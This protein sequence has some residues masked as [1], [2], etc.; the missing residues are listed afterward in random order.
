MGWQRLVRSQR[1]MRRRRQCQLAKMSS[2]G[3]IEPRH[4]CHHTR[5]YLTPYFS[6]VPPQRH[7]C[8]ILPTPLSSTTPIT[9]FNRHPSTNPNPTTSAMALLIRR[10]PHP[11]AP[12]QLQRRGFL[13]LATLPRLH[14]R[15]HLHLQLSLPILFT[16]SKFDC[17][18]IC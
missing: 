15:Q 1:T 4:R 11:T 13:L 8:I 10:R 7:L 3:N 14:L 17:L 18:F 16:R 9:S 6:S 12:P 2:Q 5:V